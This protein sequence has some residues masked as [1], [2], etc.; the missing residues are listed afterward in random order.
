VP[1]YYYSAWSITSTVAAAVEPTQ[2]TEMALP[3]FLCTTAAKENDMGRGI[4]I[5]G[6]ILLLIILWLIFG[7]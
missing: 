1:A 4:S 6:L 2:G 7:R 3:R 5:G